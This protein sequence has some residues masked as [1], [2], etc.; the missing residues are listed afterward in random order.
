LASLLLRCDLA[1]GQHV[2]IHGA[3]GGVGLFAVQI[4]KWKGARVTATAS[5][6]NHDFVRGLGADE[7]ID[8]RT[9]RFED[10]VG[11]VDAV[12][13]T[14]GGETLARSRVVLKDGGKLVTIA[15]GEERPGTAEFF[16]VEPNREQL[17]E[18]GRLI[19]R[20]VIRPIV[21]GVFRLDE[22]RAAYQYKP[23]RGKAVIRID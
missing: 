13:D 5:A 2:L 18:V 1:A 7:V 4:A 20:N 10:A 17:I 8:Y 3:A 21:D 9:T 19:D 16:I 15:A 14:V 11:K 12:F 23:R 22:A 6:H